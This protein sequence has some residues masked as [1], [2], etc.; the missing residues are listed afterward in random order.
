MQLVMMMYFVNFI[1][2]SRAYFIGKR[3]F[4]LDSIENAVQT[5]YDDMERGRRELE[6]AAERVVSFF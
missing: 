2:S 1:S 4:F 3:I 6:K 5:A